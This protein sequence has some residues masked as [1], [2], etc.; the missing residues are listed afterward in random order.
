MSESEKTVVFPI[1]MTKRGG[2]VGSRSFPYPAYGNASAELVEWIELDDEVLEYTTVFVPCIDYYVQSASSTNKKNGPAETGTGT[3]ENPWCNLNSVFTSKAIQCATQNFCCQYV[4]VHVSGIVNYYTRGQGINHNNNL[5][6]IFENNINIEWNEKEYTRN[7]GPCFY[8][9]VG[10]NFSGLNIKIS[11]NN[12]TTESKQQVDIYIDIFSN[13]KNCI[14]YKITADVIMY[15]RVSGTD[16]NDHAALYCKTFRTCFGLTLV[17]SSF[18]LSLGAR[19]AEDEE[20]DASVAHSQ[21]VI[22]FSSL[23]C[24]IL[25][26]TLRV[27]C[28]SYASDHYK[29]VDDDSDFTSSIAQAFGLY[30]SR[31]AIIKESSITAIASASNNGQCKRSHIGCA[32]GHGSTNATIYNSN[33]SHSSVSN[34]G[35]NRWT[36]SLIFECIE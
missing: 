19:S 7:V 30:D 5:I 33:L 18:D 21:G 27:E 35:T 20:G 24:L 15:N 6:L 31:G 26:S 10:V 8:D 13:C 14:F 17:N 2:M 32:I 28:V 23:S 16:A 1:M 12:T 22:L 11:A 36:T 9:M 29:N 4:A 25:D 3:K 34:N